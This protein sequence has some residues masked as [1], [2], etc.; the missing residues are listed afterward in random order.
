MR[1][2]EATRTGLAVAGAAAVGLIAGIAI[3]AGR[4]AMTQA[5]E[6]MTGDWLDALKA[7]HLMIMDLF[8]DLEAT[9]TDDAGKR[10]RLVGRIRATI[11]KHA[12]EEETVVYPAVRL[13][14]GDELAGKLV[15]EHGE[16]MSLLYELDTVAPDSLGFMKTA[17]ALRRVLEEH[18][19]EEEDV[20]FPRLRER[21]TPG[22]DARLTA[23]L[24][25][26]GLKLA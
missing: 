2:G 6:A 18:I 8:Y 26:A 5:A 17:H 20:V 13:G 24:H 16:M 11:E 19:R 22:M 9:T 1:N 15:L 21:L 14:E 4:K 3:D 12:F 7:E 25:K 23:L 10:R